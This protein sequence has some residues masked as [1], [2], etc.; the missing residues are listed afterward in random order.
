MTQSG[1]AA[2]H[3][4]VLIAGPPAMYWNLMVKGLA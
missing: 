3:H 4:S 2:Q 1:P